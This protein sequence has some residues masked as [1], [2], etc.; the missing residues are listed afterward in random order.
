ME[1]VKHA[2][3]SVPKTGLDWYFNSVVLNIMF[4]S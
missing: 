1:N 2:E 4:R 3:R